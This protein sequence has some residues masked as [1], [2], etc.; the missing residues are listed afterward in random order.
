MSPAAADLP[1]RSVRL[2]IGQRLMLFLGAPLLAIMLVS[3]WADYSVARR[4]AV[5]AYDQG[6]VDAALALAARVAERD[7]RILVRLDASAIDILR[8]DRADAVYFAVLD[9]GGRLVAGDAGLA[10]PVPAPEANPAMF[11]ATHN[12]FRVRGVRYALE[13]E[14]GRVTVLFAE[15]TAKREAAARTI[16]VAM[17][18]PNLAM[19]VVTLALVL[20][21]VRSGLAPLSR[22]RN[23]IEQRSARDLRPLSVEAAPPDILPLM[24]ALNRLFS[25]LDS[26]SKAQG[27]FVENAAHQLRTPLAALRTQLDLAATDTDAESRGARLQRIVEA[28]DRLSRLVNRLLALARSEPAATLQSQM[29]EIDLRAL[30]ENAASE[31]L[32]AAVARRIDLGFELQEASIEGIVWLVREMLG[33]LL[34][35]A[36]A[37]TSEGGIVTVRTGRLDG[38]SF[39][40]VE[41]NGPGIPADQ[42]DRVF[43]RF[44]RLPGTSGHGSGLG[45][46]IVREIAEA[47]RAE[48]TISTPAS[49]TGTRIMA[50]FPPPGA[51]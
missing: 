50:V 44:Y 37:Y 47:H 36:I 8:A 3:A 32:D 40:E 13:T 28:T 48:V 51:R 45:L 42:R 46:A 22:L 27:Q 35:N 23:D 49:G 39:L 1:S 41:D 15:T 19:V 17:L 30:V 38:R 4:M 33:N 7:G 10:P 34:D 6:L 2:S 20:A 31:F 29:R 9:A 21:A 16:F 24:N 25:L 12:G 14:A 11:D 26:A 18:A 43:D 5:H